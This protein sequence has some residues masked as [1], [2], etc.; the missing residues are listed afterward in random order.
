MST[1]KFTPVDEV[2]EASANV[3]P[4]GVYVPVF[5]YLRANPGKPVKLQGRPHT[6]VAYNIN[7]GKYVGCEPSEFRAY[8]RNTK[9]GR[10]DIYVTYIG[11]KP[12][13]DYHERT[14]AL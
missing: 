11:P 7:N 12:N 4:G 6:S 5:E 2:P 9:A 3:N 10:G 13:E 1:I 14:V 8:A